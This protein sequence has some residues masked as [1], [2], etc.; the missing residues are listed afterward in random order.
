[1]TD[2]PIIARGKP[3]EIPI[4]GE[5]V[6]SCHLS[7]LYRPGIPFAPTDTVPLTDDEIRR[8]AI[9]EGVFG[10]VMFDHGGELE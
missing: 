2:F 5:S 7:Q 8:R 1:M 6:T 9:G 4:K 10:W 3:K